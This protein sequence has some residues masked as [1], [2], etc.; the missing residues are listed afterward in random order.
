MSRGRALAAVTGIGG[1]RGSGSILAV[2]VVAAMLGLVAISTPLYVVLSAK[3]RAMA[4]ADAAALAAASVAL[5]IVPGLPCAAAASL[6]TANGASLTRCE[7]DGAIVTVRVS[8]S[9]MGFAVP[10]AATA[11]PPGTEHN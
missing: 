1:D 7:P 8:V 6:A 3:Q 2:A 5:G 9:A 11:G 4:A 10:A